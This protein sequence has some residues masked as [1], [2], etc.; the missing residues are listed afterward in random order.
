MMQMK[1]SGE[2]GRKFLRHSV[3]KKLE[4]QKTPLT[5]QNENERTRGKTTEDEF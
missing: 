3:A 2:N 1:A 5:T 4:E